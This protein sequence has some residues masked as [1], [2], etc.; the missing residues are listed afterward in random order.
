MEFFRSSKGDV[1]SMMK[2]HVHYFGLSETG[3]VKTAGKALKT[4]TP[5][6]P[7]GSS[8][9]STQAWKV[10]LL[11]HLAGVSLVLISGGRGLSWNKPHIYFIFSP[12]ASSRSPYGATVSTADEEVRSFSSF[13]R[14]GAMLEA[15]AFP[16]ALLG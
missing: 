5:T 8:S 2:P 4:N 12:E 14:S 13:H 3:T 6:Q 1:L 9:P 7:L 11:T 16:F 15:N 10:R